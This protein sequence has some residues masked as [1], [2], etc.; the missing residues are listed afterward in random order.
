M[1]YYELIIDNELIVDNEL[2]K[3]TKISIFKN[4]LSLLNIPNNVC[5]NEV[6]LVIKLKNKGMSKSKSW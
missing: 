6:T 5:L 1:E 2:I 3:H 4:K